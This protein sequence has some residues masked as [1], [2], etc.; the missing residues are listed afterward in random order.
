MISPCARVDVEEFEFAIAGI[1][2]VL[3]LDK[4]IVVCG[5][6]ESLG[7]LFQDG[8]ID[9]LYKGASFAKLERV[10]A[11]TVDHHFTDCFSMPK[12]STV[13]ELLRSPAWNQFLN[14]HFVWP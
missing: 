13:R 5:P 14:H 3:K 9:S 10:L 12:E 11:A 6:K 2:L 8:N 1:E 7:I 4:P